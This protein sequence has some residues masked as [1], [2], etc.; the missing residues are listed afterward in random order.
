MYFPYLRGRQYEL[1]ALRELVNKKLLGKNITP[2]I[3]PVKLSSTL[4]K[5]IEEFIGEKRN[6]AI[7]RNPKVGSFISEMKDT[8]KDSNREKFLSFLESE[9]IINAH[10]MEKNS[11]TKLKKWESKGVGK[12]D[13]LIINNNRD[14]LS[15]FE[16]EFSEIYP[17]YVLI[18]DES[19]FRRKV[20][21]HR[22]LLDDKFEKRNR[23]SDYIEKEDEFFSEDHLLFETDGFEGFSDYSVI[24]S[25]YLE[26]GFAPYAVAIH[27]VYFTKDNILRVR[28][29]V[30]DSNED[31][32]DPAGKFYEAVQKLAHWCKQENIKET[33]G[34]RVLLEHYCDKTYPG[35]GSVKKLAVMHHLELID[36]YLSEGE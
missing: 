17:R 18:P 8:N 35:L 19:A 11:S 2:I 27:I 20:K 31:I 32:Q 29:F 10:I 22:V 6:I 16:D 25:D 13:W 3:E 1:L 5:T 4:I 26:S 21:R 23:N 36:K 28:H 24:G 15:I 7:I 12:G 14:S 30:S 33:F 34:L 9:Y